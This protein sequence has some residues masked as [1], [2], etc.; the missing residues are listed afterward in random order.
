MSDQ[1]HRTAESLQHTI[2]GEQSHPFR[3]SLRNQNAVERIAMM[4]RQDRQAEN[5]AALHRQPGQIL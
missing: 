3:G 1:H 5:M 4:A 2:G